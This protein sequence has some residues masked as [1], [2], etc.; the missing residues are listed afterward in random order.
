MYL[1]KQ[2]TTVHLKQQFFIPPSIHP[3]PHNNQS[4]IIKKCYLNLNVSD[5]KLTFFPQCQQSQPRSHPPAY[6]AC[7]EQIPANKSNK[8]ITYFKNSLT[9]GNEAGK[10]F[11]QRYNLLIFLMTICLQK[12]PFVL[13]NQNDALGGWATYI[14]ERY[15][16][17]YTALCNG[18]VSQGAEFGGLRVFADHT[19]KSKCKTNTF[20][21]FASCTVFLCV[22]C[23]HAHAGNTRTSRTTIILITAKTPRPPN[24]APC[25]D[26]DGTGS[27]I[28]PLYLWTGHNSW[29]LLLTFMLLFQFWKMCIQH[30]V[31]QAFNLGFNSKLPVVW[32]M[33]TVS[34]ATVNALSSWLF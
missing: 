8:F 17:S 26:Q 13:E 24:W 19:R 25:Q 16:T 33:S 11:S 21:I 18:V 34:H 5:K 22:F 7:Q 20:T 30:S 14:E 32:K 15:Q 23:L 1:G 4:E 12:T 9:H 27:G 6:W 10:L 31:I 2:Q 28:S 3:V 29:Q